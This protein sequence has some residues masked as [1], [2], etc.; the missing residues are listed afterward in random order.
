MTVRSAGEHFL[1]QKRRFCLFFF[2]FFPLCGGRWDA[3]EGRED[4]G[5]WCGKRC[6]EVDQVL[7]GRPRVEQKAFQV[8]FGHFPYVLLEKP[9]FPILWGTGEE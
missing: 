2:F 4:A 3:R 6:G 5:L 1:G 8:F 9:T 7:Q